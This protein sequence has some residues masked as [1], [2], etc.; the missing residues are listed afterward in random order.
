MSISRNEPKKKDSRE[1][2]EAQIETNCPQQ[3]ACSHPQNDLLSFPTLYGGTPYPGFTSHKALQ[4]HS[5]QTRGSETSTC[6]ESF[7][8]MAASAHTPA[9]SAQSIG[10]EVTL[11]IY[12]PLR[13]TTSARMGGGHKNQRNQLMLKRDPADPGNRDSGTHVIWS[14]P[15]SPDRRSCCNSSRQMG[16]S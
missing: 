1:I 11:D 14:P 6:T 16:F 5:L 2:P 8:C 4:G 15:A 7:P 13:L 3:H 10:L 12:F 9:S